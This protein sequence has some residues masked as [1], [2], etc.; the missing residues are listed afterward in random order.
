M[1][2]AVAKSTR[3]RDGLAPGDEGME[4]SNADWHYIDKHI[5]GVSLFRYTPPF[6]HSEYGREFLLE[7]E[8]ISKSATELLKADAGHVA[9]KPG[10]AGWY[11]SHCSTLM[12]C[13]RISP[14]ESTKS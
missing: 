10:T 11:C 13:S 5:C 12:A 1:G 6:E 4:G 8:A 7:Y 14:R 9:V 3:F 2:C